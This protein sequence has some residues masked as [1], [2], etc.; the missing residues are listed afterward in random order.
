MNPNDFIR[1]WDGVTLRE[2]QVSQ[3]HFNDLCRLLGLSDP[4]AA[5]PAG[6]W[7][8]FE[9]GATKAGGGEG[10]ADV[11]RRGCFA[12][13]YKSPGKDLEAAF[14]QLQLYTPALAYPP[15]LIV[16]D[17]QV[18]RIHTA[19]TGLVPTTYI[20]T[21]DDLRDPAKLKWLKWAFTDPERLKP[22]Q[23][24]AHLTEQAAAKLGALAKNP[25]LRNLDNVLLRDAILNPDG[26]E[27]EWPRGG[28]HRWESAVFGGE[29]APGQ[30]GRGLREPTP[31]PLSGSGAG[32]R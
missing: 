21:L 23:T 3:S 12:W 14:K 10:W 1:K 27:P 6:E 9:K 17:I 13:E 18:I 16:S 15:L 31:L 26:S 25:I 4:I 2:K 24:R 30:S 28:S 19:F 8:C 32:W 22:S 29:Q 11:W 20:I 5:D 7:F